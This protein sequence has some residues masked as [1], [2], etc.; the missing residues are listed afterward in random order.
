MKEATAEMR[1]CLAVGLAERS[2]I[3]VTPTSCSPGWPLLS[4]C[5][6][7]RMASPRLSF[8]Q[9]GGSRTRSRRASQRATFLEEPVDRDRSR[10]PDREPVT[11]KRAPCAARSTLRI[12]SCECGQEPT[13]LPEEDQRE[14]DGMS[15][16]CRL[17]LSAA[18]RCTASVA[19]GPRSCRR[20]SGRPRWTAVAHG[21]A[22][23]RAPPL[24]YSVARLTRAS[25][26]AAPSITK[27]SATPPGCAGR[28]G[29]RPPS[30][31]AP[32]SRP[33]GEG[34]PHGTSCSYRPAGTGGGDVP[35]TAG[36]RRRAP[37]TPR[38][39]TADSGFSILPAWS[40]VELCL[41]QARRARSDAS[42]AIALRA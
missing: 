23:Q 1:T 14:A 41:K 5:C 3:P 11:G 20:S 2:R 36:S 22:L 26:H 42:A 34:P 10:E 37:R 39:R 28:R 31:L 29:R 18:A 38:P 27:M 40:Q 25:S 24:T 7:G 33:P 19:R 8:A 32:P 15:R 21:G 35:A 17:V 30:H 4:L 9:W 6:S 12:P 16:R 13:E